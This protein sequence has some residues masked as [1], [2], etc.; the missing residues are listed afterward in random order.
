[1][2]ARDFLLWLWREIGIR[3]NISKSS[4]TPSQALDYLGMRLQ[5][6]PLR[7]FPTP[8]RVLKLSSLVLNFASCRQQ[9]LTLASAAGCHVIHVSPRSGL[10]TL[11]AFLATSVEHCRLFSPG[12]HH[13]VLGQLLP[14]GSSVVV[15]RFPSSRGSYVRPSLARSLDVHGR[16]GFRLG[17]FAR[18]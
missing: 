2:Q 13:R 17:R 14:R 1:M 8:K 9:P 12:L 5:M 3:V 7:V 10:S 6:R 15:H 4:L 16:L 11:D 18:G